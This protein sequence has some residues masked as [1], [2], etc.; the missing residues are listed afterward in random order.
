[1]L[2]KTIEVVAI[3]LLGSAFCAWP[4]FVFGSSMRVVANGA[5]VLTGLPL[6]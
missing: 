3:A 2:W 6:S 1:M 4:P 5:T